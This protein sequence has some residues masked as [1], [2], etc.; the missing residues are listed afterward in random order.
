MTNCKI[1]FTLE[2]FQIAD[3]LTWPPYEVETAWG[4]IIGEAEARM[5]NTPFF[6]KGVSYLDHVSF[7][8]QPDGSFVADGVLKHL[9]HST[10]RA[11]LISDD[12]AP[13]AS[14]AVARTKAFGCTIEWGGCIAAIDVPP[15]VS[16]EQILDLLREAQ[17]Q[18]A[19]YVDV[20]YISTSE[21]SP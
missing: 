14:E 4:E 18:D 12:K 11:I 20:G 17:A 15:G 8:R 9:G 1:G 7:K 6:A 5:L 19:I 16:G 2:K 3:D 13:I 10:I 21:S